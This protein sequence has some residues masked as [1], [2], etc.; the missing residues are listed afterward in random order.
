M[1]EIT[2]CQIWGSGHNATGFTEPD[3]SRALVL[4]S[5]RAGGGYKLAGGVKPFLEN[6]G[7]AEKS[8]LTTWLVD[9]RIRGVD[10]PEVTE[11]VVRRIRARRPLQVHER[12]DRLLRFI[13]SVTDVV[14]DYAEISPDSCDPACAWSESTDWQ[15][16]H[17]F[18]RYLVNNGCLEAGTLEHN[19]FKGW[20]TVDGHSR[21]AE[22]E[23]NLDSVQA[24]VAMWFDKSM[25]EAYRVGIE[26]GIRESGYRAL[27]IDREEYVDKIDDRIVAEIRRSRFLVADF[28]QGKGGA[29]GGV[30]YEA[31]FAY[32]LGIPVFYTCHADLVEYLHLD[33][34]QYNH[35][36]WKTPDELRE[37]LR[38]R[39]RRV[40]GDGPEIDNSPPKQG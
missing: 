8:R 12:A 30:Y 15:E 20:A 14:G 19:M 21:I 25:N 26:P 17:Y 13:A 6:M 36:L 37:S 10:Q 4:D 33:T 23:V 34:R 40:L 39:I 24:F 9:Q 2:T 32:G 27:R 7:L 31:G 18:L 16:V 22:Q 28:T 5:P 38:N 1:N 29:R 3:L 11:A 35:I